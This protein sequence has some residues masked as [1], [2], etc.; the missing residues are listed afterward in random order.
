MESPGYNGD[1]V[2]CVSGDA[3]WY[4]DTNLLLIDSV[5]PQVT[6]ISPNFKNIIW[7]LIICF[8]N[9]PLETHTPRVWRQHDYRD[10]TSKTKQAFIIISFIF[11]PFIFIHIFDLIN[12]WI[13]EFL[14]NLSW[15]QWIPMETRDV[16]FEYR[17]AIVPFC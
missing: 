12:H 6:I 17:R 11:I 14:I 3:M 13:I 4:D 1:H 5:L 8:I 2:C 10:V 7:K 15:H 16:L 9:F